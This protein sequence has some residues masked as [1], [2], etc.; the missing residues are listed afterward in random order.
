MQTMRDQ[1]SKCRNVADH[2]DTTDGA[3]WECQSCGYF[4]ATAFQIE[5][6]KIRV[7]YTGTLKE[8]IAKARAIDAEYQ[9]TFGTQVT[10]GTDVLWDSEH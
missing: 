6:V 8:A 9:P 5:S 3:Y 10:L 4:S 7:E 1:C 2:V